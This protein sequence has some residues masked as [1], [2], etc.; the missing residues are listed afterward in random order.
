MLTDSEFFDSLIEP[1]KGKEAVWQRFFEENPWILGI[2][3]G[4]QLLTSWSEDRLEQF[5]KGHSIAGFGK[6]A[7]A[8]LQ[9]SGLVRSTLPIRSAGPIF[10]AAP[11]GT[12]D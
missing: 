7:D 10:P 11:F 5:V 8:L 6:R 4:S 12:T 9:T 1:G 2:G 3:L